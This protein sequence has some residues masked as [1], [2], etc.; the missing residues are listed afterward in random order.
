MG[1]FINADAFAATG[2]GLIGNNMFAYCRN[3]PVVR[4]DASGTEDVNV[5]DFKQNN[6]P[7]DDIGNPTGSGGGG[8]IWGSFVRTLK[9]ATN[10]LK[11][12]AG[13]RDLTHIEDHHIISD[14]NST[15]PIDCK[16]IV[17]RYH[18]SLDHSSN[19]VP[20][21]GHRG[22]HTNAY[23]E[24]I[25]TAIKELDVIAAGNTDLFIDGMKE[26]GAF[27][28]EYWWLPYARTK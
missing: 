8:N 22:R 27:I 19:I 25:T 28:K 21:Q 24:F 7:F 5:E 11:M 14:K 18:Y 1:R 12:A 16:E 17:D 15:Q 10:G 2:Q 26:L 6:T 3:N 13:Q 23:H 4:K 9:Q 20:L